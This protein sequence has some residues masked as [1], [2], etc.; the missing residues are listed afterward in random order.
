MKYAFGSK[1]RHASIYMR[2]AR[3]EMPNAGAE[4]RAACKFGNLRK[5]RSINRGEVSVYGCKIKGLR[6]KFQVTS[7]SGFDSH[8][9][10]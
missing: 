5:H 1:L 10:P 6:S 3:H 4:S 2:S 7:I 9:S 8:F